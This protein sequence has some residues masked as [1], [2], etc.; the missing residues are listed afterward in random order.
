M[1]GD[2]DGQAG[3]GERTAEEDVRRA[4][5]GAVGEV[6][7]NQGERQRGGDWGDSV[8]LGLYGGVAEGL[9]DG[10]REV[11]EGVG[12]DDDGCWEAGT[13]G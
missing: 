1:D 5:L 8:Q 4:Q 12:G 9:D 7:E 11:G 3:D 13:C 2:Q 6:G 10:G